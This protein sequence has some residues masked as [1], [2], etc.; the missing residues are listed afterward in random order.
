MNEDLQ[1]LLASL[2]LELDQVQVAQVGVVL[3]AVQVHLHHQREAQRQLAALLDHRRL[4]P[5][6]PKVTVFVVLVA[7]VGLGEWREL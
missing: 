4:P 6:D 3:H 1:G 5:K 2:L 7:P